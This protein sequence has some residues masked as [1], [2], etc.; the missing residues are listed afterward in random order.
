[1]DLNANDLASINIMEY[2]L[3][4]DDHPTPPLKKQQSS[5][6][7]N[8]TASGTKMGNFSKL[9]SSILSNQKSNNEPNVSF[10]FDKQNTFNSFYLTNDY[11]SGDIIT[12]NTNSKNAK[13]QQTKKFQKI[14]HERL[15]AD[16]VEEDEDEV[17][18]ES[19]K[20]HYE[21]KMNAFQQND[22][23]RDIKSKQ[24]SN[25][26]T[27]SNSNISSIGATHINNNN[28]VIELGKHKLS[29]IWNNVKYGKL[30]SVFYKYIAMFN[31]YRNAPYLDQVPK[32]IFHFFFDVRTRY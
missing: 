25:V 29:S 24:F 8:G 22:N 5:S 16:I 30:Y 11:D 32:V 17:V 27:S 7:G 13:E 21:Q 14:D 19:L 26:I 1:M 2:S 23:K 12:V 15:D 18:L 20:G 9:K 4:L 6:L 3:C 28:N 10:K 31:N